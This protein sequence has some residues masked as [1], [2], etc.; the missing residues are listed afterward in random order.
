MQDFGSTVKQPPAELDTMGDPTQ[1]AGSP[2]ED[3]TQQDVSQENHMPYNED[4]DGELSEMSSN[5]ESQSCNHGGDGSAGTDCG[6]VKY[7]ADQDSLQPN[8]S[9]IYSGAGWQESDA[10]LSTD[11]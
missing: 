10:Q 9:S 5:P 3:L 8:S 2:H 11:N 4:P 1:G 6:R 7:P